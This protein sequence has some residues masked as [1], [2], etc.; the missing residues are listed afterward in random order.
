MVQPRLPSVSLEAEGTSS[1]TLT[2]H[3]RTYTHLVI[4]GKYFTNISVSLEAEVI[5]VHQVMGPEL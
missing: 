1:L 4:P 5:P 2:R 3:I